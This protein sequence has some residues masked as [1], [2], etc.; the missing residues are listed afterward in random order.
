MNDDHGLHRVD[1]LFDV[2]DRVV[3]VTGGSRGIGELIARAFVERGAEVIISSRSADACHS[4]AEELRQV[5]RCRALPADVSTTEGI[6]ELVRALSEITDRLDVLVNNAGA[7]WGAELGSFPEF[8]WDKTLDLN[9]KSPFFLI[10]ELLPAMRRAVTNGSPARI[11]NIASIDGLR[12][13]AFES[14]A[15]AASKAGLLMLTR[16]LAKRLAAEQILVNAIAPGFFRTKM[17][18]DVLAD[19]ADIVRDIP[20]S[21][22]G[23]ASD[24]GGTAIFLACKASS[25]MTGA[26]L[27]CDGGASTV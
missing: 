17:T 1:P 20:L 21:R 9:L 24:I 15:Y 12:P 22:L 23:T 27:V 25:Y 13:P 4:V 5:G 19:E 26:T 2:R 10:Q 7:T 11:I 6:F 8:G 14:Y 3:L 18:K 16:H